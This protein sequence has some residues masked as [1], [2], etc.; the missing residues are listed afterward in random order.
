[1]GLLLAGLAGG[2]CAADDRPTVRAIDLRHEF[3][4]AE[5]RPAEGAF[6]IAEHALLGTRY[7]GIEAP[8]ASRLIWTGKLPA[9]A[10]LRAMVAVLAAAGGEA[11]INFR[12]GVSDER[13]YEALAE[14]RVSAARTREVGW[15]P[16]SADLSPY[17]GRKWSVF[18]RPGAKVWR[19]VLSTDRI[20]GNG[21][22]FWGSPGVDS[23]VEAAREWRSRP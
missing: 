22:A 20:D 3:S 6:A 5:K 7:A 23:D 11:T 15:I 4:R 16:L 1:M 10:T 8:P 9:R 21:R 18:Y 2:G 12:V 14:Q 17:A 13:L 19:L